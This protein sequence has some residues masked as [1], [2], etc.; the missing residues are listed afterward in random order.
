MRRLALP[1]VILTSTAAT[2]ERMTIY[3]SSNRI[4]GYDEHNGDSA[5]HYDA[6]NR[7]TD[8]SER[9]GDRLDH[10]VGIWSAAATSRAALSKSLPP[11]FCYVNV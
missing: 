11:A 10:Q 6:N 1:L 8:Q 5:I 2:A 4:F 9:R 3:D 7:Q